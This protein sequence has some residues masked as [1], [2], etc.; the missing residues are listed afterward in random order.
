MRVSATRPPSG[1]PWRDRV[2]AVGPPPQDGH[3][4][5][6][7][8]LVDRRCRDERGDGRRGRERYPDPADEEHREDGERR[9]HSLPDRWPRL[10]TEQAGDGVLARVTVGQRAEAHVALGGPHALNSSVPHGWL[11][12]LGTATPEVPPRRHGENYGDKPRREWLL[13][14]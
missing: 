1:R 12:G 9:D 4:S 8:G 11:H 5:E 2:G 14:L 3:P 10:R 13:N 6:E 7:H